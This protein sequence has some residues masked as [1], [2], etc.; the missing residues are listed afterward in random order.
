MNDQA[1]FYSWCFW[2]V[3]LYF[4][5]FC[6]PGFAET[7]NSW[8]FSSSRENWTSGGTITPNP[9][10]NHHNADGWPGI[11]YADCTGSDPFFV[12]P[13]FSLSAKNY[14]KIV[15]KIATHGGYS[16][17]MRVYWK[18]STDSSFI[19]SRSVASTYYASSGTNFKTVILDVGQSSNWNGTI[20]S[21]RIDP[22]RSTCSGTIRYHIDAV[23][24]EGTPSPPPKPTQSSPS[25]YDTFYKGDTI[26]FRWNNNGYSGT[27]WLKVYDASGS[28]VYDNKFSSRTSYSWTAPTNKSGLFR[29]EITI[30]S[31]G[32]WSSWAS[33][34]FYVKDPPKPLQTSPSNGSSFDYDSRITFKWNNN[35]LSGSSWFRVLDS[36]NIIDEYQFPGGATEKVWDSGS[37]PEGQYRWQVAFQKNGVWSGWS[38]RHFYINAP[39]PPPPPSFISPGN[40]SQFFCGDRIAF[41]WNNN[42][43]S[44]AIWLKVFDQNGNPEVD[45]KF[46]AG[47]T[48][49]D[50]TSTKTKS[51][52][53][54]W[55]LAIQVNNVWSEWTSR[56]FKLNKPQLT[57]PS[58]EL[59]IG[60]P[61]I[62]QC[63]V[64]Q[65]SAGNDVGFFVDTQSADPVGHPSK[66]NSDGLA[67][68]KL[69]V[70]KDWAS[71][72]S[73]QCRDEDRRT[74]SSWQ[75][76]TIQQPVVE[77]SPL[78][79]AQEDTFTIKGSGFSS[80][81][82]M[83][84][85]LIDPK[86]NQ[87]NIPNPS[88]SKGIFTSTWTPSK[89]ET[90]GY[91]H[92]SVIAADAGFVSKVTSLLVWINNPPPSD[93]VHGILARTIDAPEVYWIKYNKK[94]LIT[95]STDSEEQLF[96]G[97]GYQLSD[98]GW[99]ASGALANFADGKSVLKNDDQFCYR[100][101]D[102]DQSAVFII[103]NKESHPFYDWPTFTSQGFD[104]D[105]IFWASPKG[106]N[107]IQSL[108]PYVKAPMIRV[109]PESLTF[110][111]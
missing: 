111:K 26:T 27:N 5:C 36:S 85:K 94:W 91:Y 35:G 61:I 46:S 37:H 1:R 108:Y 87:V 40:N 80:N 54:R 99:Y 64:G 101:T 21:I 52:S 16:H 13:S 68:V 57:I 25:S 32:L 10:P 3:F 103:E 107:Y 59:F 29:W 100:S 11:I 45:K 62:L 44:G 95:G 47:T 110:E 39:Q 79:A 49:H 81:Q 7:Y 92:C 71:S 23:S 77:I 18:R 86:G 17:E 38:E 93:T 6:I 56:N 15:V 31:D 84:I 14:H 30:N 76:K 72:V 109:K 66:A 55:E 28:A 12:S 69:T 63:Q 102:N 20:K 67:S 65:Q 2:L 42:G 34:P 90:S 98:I 104:S 97:L 73:F 78:S 89:D 75:K 4:L 19:E 83:T 82:V 58:T 53:F 96:F 106:V 50:W 24:I 9:T 22:S 60:D 8:N 74:T 33:R 48:S 51:G 88:I 43:Y 105:D 70:T 41:R